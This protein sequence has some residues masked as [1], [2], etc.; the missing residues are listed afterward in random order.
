MRPFQLLPFSEDRSV[1]VIQISV[2][3]GVTRF[4]SGLE[5]ASHLADRI[6]LRWLR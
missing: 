2:H 1:Q 3:S 5:H 4:V 6:H